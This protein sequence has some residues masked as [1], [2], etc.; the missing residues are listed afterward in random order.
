MKKQFTLK[1]WMN[2]INEQLV[3]EDLAWNLEL[4]SD[5]IEN[6]RSEGKTESF[7]WAL[8]EN[9]IFSNNRRTPK[10]QSFEKA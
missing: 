1:I 3:R 9:G 7:T 6:G 4:I 8:V 5:D 10:D 2:V